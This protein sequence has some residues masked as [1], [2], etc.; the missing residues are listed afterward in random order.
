MTMT[1]PDPLR[2]LLVEDNEDDFLIIRDFLSD[3]G[4]ERFVLDR[5][6]TYEGGLGAVKS[7]CHDLVLLD[8]R[9]PGRTGMELLSEARTVSPGVPVILMTG[10]GGQEI[11]IQAMQAGA[12]DYLV[13]DHLDAELLKRAIRHAIERQKATDALRCLLAETQARSEREAL[14]NRIAQALLAS[15]DP[16]IFQ[17]SAVALLGAALG[18]DRCYLAAWDADHDRL[19]IYP[20]FR[21]AGLPSLAGEHDLPAYAPVVDALFAAGIA[22]VPDL[23]AS[24]LPDAV[25]ALMKGFAQRAVLA[26]PF[27][28]GEGRIITALWVATADTPRAWV[29]EEV[30]LAGTVAA[31]TCAAM[32]AAQ[33]TERA[34][35]IAAQ[36]QASLT[37]TIPA[38]IPGMALA[39]YYEAALDEANVG[40]D[41]YDVFPILRNRTALIVGDLMGKGLAA[42]SQVATVRNMLRYALYRSRTVAGALRSLNS[43]VVGQCLLTDFATLF[44]GIYDGSDGMLRYV[45][46]G[47]EPALVR[48]AGGFIEPLDATGPALG[49]F[50]STDFEEKTITL[51][52]GEALAV[53]TDGLTEVGRSRTQMLGIEGVAALLRPPLTPE[54]AE[55]S[56]R[57]AETLVLRLVGG[58]EAAAQGGGATDDVCILVAVVE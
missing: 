42:A 43:L 31:L 37:P 57:M 15:T 56:E 22:V 53:F 3:T 34:R 55:N 58:V 13:K 9:L 23:H 47:Q 35:N 32:H 33:A 14:V 10:Q 25:A 21:R 50:E 1:H 41:F 39:K 2:I 16:V 7:Q 4:T 40:G 38:R 5:E 52:V 45:N 44:V 30:S 36:L 48:R 20:D 26:V 12:T 11:D 46:C 54:E 49:L 29:P 27:I 19:L 28:E 6:E 18:A 8:Y 17:R 51:G 24:G